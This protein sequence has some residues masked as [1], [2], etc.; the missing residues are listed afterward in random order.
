LEAQLAAVPERVEVIEPF[1]FFGTPNPAAD[2]M[3]AEAASVSCIN[4][5]KQIGLS[6]RIWANDNDGWYP[7]NLN[8]MSNEL[9]VASVLCCREDETN[10]ELARS[11][12]SSKR[13]SMTDREFYDRQNAAWAR[14][15]V[16]GGT[17]EM[18]TA[19]AHESNVPIKQLLARCR[20]HGHWVQADGAAFMAGKDYTQ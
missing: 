11:L 13:E 10:L 9:S 5:L 19:S 3:R 4:N 1:D 6:F 7:P 2:E 17:Y 14:W 18:L 16:N 8:S 20:I 12:F 15:P